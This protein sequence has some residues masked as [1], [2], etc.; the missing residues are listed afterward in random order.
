[1]LGCRSLYL[2]DWLVV[3]DVLNLH[4]RGIHLLLRRDFGVFL[5]REFKVCNEEM[6]QMTNH[7]IMI[8]MTNIKT[9]E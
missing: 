3:F 1:L 9:Q 5:K 4:T 7:L 6:I 2:E 8:Q